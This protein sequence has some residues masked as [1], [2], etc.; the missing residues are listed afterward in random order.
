MSIY[1]DHNA[2]TPLAPEVLDAMLPWLRGF[3]GNPAAAC[4]LA[5]PA[6]EAVAQAREQVA[7]LAGCQPDEVVFSSGGTEANNAA[8]AS[9][10][11]LQP[12]RKTLVISATE[13]SSVAKTAEALIRQRPGARLLHLPVNADG[14]VEMAALEEI[15]Q[16]QRGDI[17]LVSVQA[18]NHETGVLQPVDEIVAACREVQLPCHTDAVQ[19]LGKVALELGGDG[20]DFVSFSAHKLRGPQGVGALVIRRG[21]RFEPLH[22]GG[23]QEDGRRSGTT[24]VAQIVG[25]GAAAELARKWL[26]QNDEQ[27]GPVQQAQLRDWLEQTLVQSLEEV[28]VNGGGTF[29]VPNTTNLHFSGLHADALLLGLDQH[30]LCCSAGSACSSRSLEPSPVLLAMGLDRFAARAS[31]RFSLGTETTREEVEQAAALVQR[32]VQR[33]RDQPAG[34]VRRGSVA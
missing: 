15:L 10:W 3:A 8:L 20:P 21:L 25:F 7:E 5:R 28:S 13:H 18:A 11:N 33:L 17:A 4:D 9:A 32:L 12:L 2:T 30:G 31:L 23:G 34:P 24:A 16:R 1:L 19:A 27:P 29:R 22:H 6:R 26:S 14:V